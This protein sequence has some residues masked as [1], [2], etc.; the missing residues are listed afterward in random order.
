[1][2]NIHIKL[3]SEDALGYMYK[4]IDK[5]TSLIINNDNNKWVETTFPHP[6]YI[7]KKFSI[8]DFELE[9]N[10]NSENLESDVKNHIKIY[11]NL[12]VLPRYILTDE[13]FWLWLYLDKFYSITR[14]MMRINGVSTIT[15]HWMQKQGKR[16]G[17]FFGVLSRMFFRV[18]LSEI[19]GN[20]D[21]TKWII[22]KPERFRN[23]SWRS[24]SSNKELTLGIIMGE[25][26]ACEHLN[27][28]NVNIYTE[29][30]KYISKLGSAKLLDA[31]SR[32]D[33]KLITYNL[34]IEM[35]KEKM[36]DR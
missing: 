12:K 32:E 15:D 23:L 28:E 22:E 16:R 19:D 18:E 24:Y 10:V 5:V 21:L 29:V 34:C 9:E 25:K 30:A 36:K 33:I 2:S 14:T 35:L 27:Y 31:H 20:Y 8:S 3:L 11:E 17:I 7:E 26:E 4:N 1:M 6:V 13:K